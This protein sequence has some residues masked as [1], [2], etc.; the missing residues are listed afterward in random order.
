MNHRV[1]NAYKN[2]SNQ[3]AVSEA[4]PLELIVM[5]YKRLIENL[6]DAQSQIEKGLD[7]EQSVAKALD[8]IEKGLMAA[9]DPDRGGDIAKNLAALYDWSTREILTARIKR[10]PEQLTGVIEVFKGLESAWKE[11]ATMRAQ[12]LPKEGTAARAA[13][14]AAAAR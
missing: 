4:S 7:A 1:I 11:I 12:D 5:V 3:T 9:L 10:S 13:S 14:S 6:R 8:L 2:V